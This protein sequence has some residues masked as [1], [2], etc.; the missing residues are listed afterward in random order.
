MLL[1]QPLYQPM[2]RI[3]GVRLHGELPQRLDR[4]RP[5]PRRH[6]D[7]A[8]SRRRRR[9]RRVRGRWPRRT[10][11]RRPGDDQQHEPGVRGDRHDLPDRR[12]DARLPAADRPHRRAGRPRRALREGAGPVARARRRAGLRRAAGARP[13]VGRPVRGGAAPAAG[14]RAADGP[15]RQLPDE[16]PRW[17]RSPSTTPGS[18]PQRPAGGQV[19]AS[20]AES[21]PASDPP[22]FSADDAERTKRRRP[23]TPP[24]TAAVPRRSL[25]PAV[26]IEVDGQRATIQT[27]LGRDRG[28][29][30]LH[31]HV[32]PDRD[33]RGRPARPQRRR[34]RADR[35]RRRSRRRS[36]RARRPSPATSRRPG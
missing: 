17:P 1:G 29:H 7:A 8:G 3:V 5:R 11:P 24:L 28:D 18:R 25:L 21:F 22:S 19:E 20:S 34:A 6:P 26:T 36:R 30:L 35:R 2:P 13:R 33:G 32:Q 4:D 12:R 14:P 9:V 16:L 23:T 27:G 31:E 10:R 15:P